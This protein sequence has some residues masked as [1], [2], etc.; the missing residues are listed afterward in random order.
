MTNRSRLILKIVS[1]AV[2]TPIVL[3]LVLATLLYVPPVQQ[4]AVDRV[5]SS[6]SAST[7][8][9]CRV[10][11]VRLGFPLRLALHEVLAKE[12]ADTLLYARSA[13]LDVRL[14]PLFSGV[15]DVDA[16][17]LYGVQVDT[18]QYIPDTYIRGH[19]GELTAASHG[20]DLKQELV[21]LDHATLRRADLFIALSDT[22]QQD[23]ASTPINWRILV[24]RA[25]IE[26]SRIR[27]HMPGDSM[28]IGADI[29]LVALRGG[30]FDLG[31]GRYAFRRLELRRC[32]LQYDVPQAPRAEG[33]DVNHLAV[34]Q[35]SAIVDT[36][37]YTAEGTLRAGLRKATLHERCGLAVTGVSGAVYMDSTQLQVPAL[38]LR[39]PHSRLDVGLA[40]DYRAMQAGRDGRCRAL[41][42][43]SVG[44][45]DLLA[46]AKGMVD[47]ALLKALPQQPLAL[48]A[49]VQGNVDHLTL[50]HL[51][52]AWPGVLSLTAK[53]EA[54]ALMQ[55]SRRGRVHFGLTCGRLGALRTLLP[56]DVRST[57]DVPDGLRAS[58]EASFSGDDYRTQCTVGSGRGT[59]A[60]KAHVNLHSEQYS[61]TAQAKAFPLQ[62]FVKG[63]GLGAFT[64]S[65]SASGRSF[66]VMSGRASL[67]AKAHIASL[68]YD[69]LQLGGLQL[70]ATL[71]HRRVQAAFT[72]HNPLVT[73]RGKLQATLGTA[74]YDAALEAD[75]DSIHLQRLGV[76]QQ[77]LI[78]S[79]HVQLQ[80]HTDARFT[81][82]SVQAA[83]RRNIFTTPAKSM[84][85]KDLELQV[86]AAR[87]HMEARIE[88]GDL[89][90][91][92]E[93]QHDV[94]QLGTHLSQVAA[95]MVRQGE[96]KAF[97]QAAL[98]RMM[99]SMTLHIEAGHANPLYNMLRFMGYSYSSFQMALSTSPHEGVLG[100]ARVGKLNLG[101]LTL[102]TLHT[103]LLQDTTGIRM[104]A[105]VQNFKKKNP[106]PLDMRLNAY[107]LTRSAGLELAY[108][109]ADG[110]KGVELGAKAE[111]ADGA[112]RL[113][114]YPEHPV[115]AYRKFKINKDNFIQ[116]G[117]DKSIR[118]DVALL[119]DDGTALH[120]Y[121]EPA[122]S[123]N[124]LTLSMAHVNLGEIVAFMPFLPE[125]HGMLSGD[126]HVTDDWAQRKLTAMA[127]ITAD[128]LQVAGTPLGQVGV[129]AIYLPEGEGVHRASAFVSSNGNEVLSLD[130]VYH[131]A[132]GG[133]YEGDAL[134]H[135]FPLEMLNGFL[136][137]T[138]M[139]V[140]GI[141][142]GTIHLAGQTERPVMNGQL[143]LDSAH[144]YSDVYGFDLRADEQEV[145][146]RDSRLTFDNYNLYSTGKQPLV[147]N[148]IFDM[149]D[150]SR[151]LLDLTFKANNFELINTKKKAQ[152][153]VYGRVFSNIDA[154][155]RGS[156]D[157]LMI[158]GQLQ[159]LDRTNMT[160]VLKDSPLSVDDRLNDLVKF[161]SFE[162]S[163]Q[164]AAEPPAP[165]STFDLT[166]GIDISDA[167]Q[168]H[169]SLSDDGESYVDLEG[170]GLLT[171]RM[172]QQ[173]DM[174]MT[175]RFTTHSG[176][177]KYA[178]P[179]IPLKTFTLAE[180][181][182][183]EFTGD[184]MNPTLQITAKER[185]KAVVT[186][187]GKSRSV[188]FNVGVALTK[189]LNNMGLE[190]LI[191]APEDLNVQNQLATMTPEQR[192]KTA[193]S[194]MATGMYV[195]DEGLMSEGGFK[196]NNALNAFLQNEIQHIAGSALKTI[197]INL[198]VES[199][200]SATGTST[201][202]YSFQFAKR[203]W[204]N[205]VSVI[206]GGKVSTGADATN[207]AESF[208]N[209][210]SVEYRLDKS[211]TR[212]V[213]VFYD[214]N[215]NDPLE[216]Q[217][218][219]TGAGLMLRRKTDR[220]GELFLFRN[221]KKSTQPKAPAQP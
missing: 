205:R 165:E 42:D 98:R 188:A 114:L 180:G 85:A 111:L 210:V 84:M 217:L 49:E 166:L 41:I 138:D 28:R 1:I 57:I 30:D 116:L 218:T 95:E 88:A 26:K 106:Y 219:K 51:S 214:R 29:P 14:W 4:F 24:Q 171:L 23:T 161:V 157:N 191:E 60:A 207:S 127:A 50:H 149:R 160:Y 122:D 173:G 10:G 11:R 87:E 212:Y 144:I 99:P 159:V 8:T 124:D 56:A 169:C 40:F 78:V 86:A 25:D 5:A 162:D 20:V 61:L 38:N 45:A 135:D 91:Q 89:H 211:A 181:S 16:V 215:I 35:F 176:E 164:V 79:T 186:E 213:T 153:M 102:D 130:G 113:S 202:D 37:T 121:G 201:T 177:M 44:R 62:H 151:M 69:T 140:K 77:P 139:G 193:V 182:Y 185:T 72:A 80:G 168:F 187:N 17:A 101:T 9:T 66:D 112:L 93:A 108:Y 100:D 107:M 33:V 19:V 68:A 167:A 148:G 170:G 7:G 67:A 143:D 81:D 115:L 109:D 18:K 75:V 142:K 128:D 64:G 83:L 73:A 58:G 117:R 94:A 12:Q 59:L 27:L 150:F 104:E 34:S 53:G 110:E 196:A 32:A 6:L 198:G 183:V 136:A 97:D 36:L 105:R 133:S 125:M 197:D 172:T 134:L 147:M 132:D 15:V 70:D 192:S 190:F 158:R 65:L 137:G 209:N 156:L 152:S 71:R 131:E 154:S 31:R 55:P 21:R 46:L 206:I 54:D 221:K 76:T 82:Y 200:T 96:Q 203:F 163:T 175:G 146:M 216:G 43:A 123:A 189:P 129:E 39:T 179:V 194:M 13:L 174:R 52:A 74:R 103:H 178:L 22:A 141:A 120:L 184:V 195:T 118:A 3:F 155:V 145:M 90:L 204:G 199:G 220:L 47:D 126:V 63:M 119:A 48:K 92:A 2:A 208:I